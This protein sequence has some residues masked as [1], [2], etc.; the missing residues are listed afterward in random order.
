MSCVL[1]LRCHR[2]WCACCVA[3][4]GTVLQLSTAVT[5][6]RSQLQALRGTA[7]SASDVSRLVADVDRLSAQ[8]CSMVGYAPPLF[9]TEIVAC[10]DISWTMQP[11]SL[12]LS[13]SE[14]VQCLVT[15]NE[16]IWPGVLLSA[17]G[18]AGRALAY[19]N[20]RLQQVQHRKKPVVTQSRPWLGAGAM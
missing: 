2:R 14:A 15:T 16:S 19:G 17:S 4:A 7:A 11:C 18:Q 8:V 6:L 12:H 3:V 20:G 13:A 9:L 10:V 1:S 5:S